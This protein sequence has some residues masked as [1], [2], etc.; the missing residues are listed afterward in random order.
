VKNFWLLAVL[1]MGMAAPAQAQAGEGE[2]GL[3]LGAV[4]LYR[5][6]GATRVKALLEVPHSLLGTSADGKLRFWIGIRVQDSTGL[7]IMDRGWAQAA[8]AVAG[9]RSAASIEMLEFAVAPGRYTLSVRVHDSLSGKEYQASR[10]I[11]GFATAPMTSDL[12]LTP[13]L[14]VADPADTVPRGGE[15]R[16]GNLVLVATPYVRVAP[17]AGQLYYMLEAYAPRTDT[18]TISV[19]VLT[20]QGVSLTRTKPRVLQVDSGGSIVSGGL[21]LGGVPQGKYRL[22]VYASIG[23]RDTTGEAEF[24]VRQPEIAQG[25]GVV[26]TDE[27]YFTNLTGKQLDSLAGALVYIAEP[28]EMAV[29]KGN[30]SPQAKVRFLT[31]FWAKRDP[32]PGQPGN[33]ARD[34]FYARIGYVDREF[35]DPGRGATPGWRTDRG[36][37][38]LK[39]GP[40]DDKWERPQEGR[41]PPLEVWRYTKTRNKYFIFADRSRIGLFSLA[42][43]D[44]V[45]EPGRP[46]WQELIG[47]YG[48]QAVERYLGVDLGLRGGQP[49]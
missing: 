14:R 24:S 28:G 2:E 30:L 8:R 48:L 32:T 49:R 16:H 12:V 41:T 46:D 37:I 6:E 25:V 13:A 15:W 39:Y 5:G 20:D 33:G 18:A 42:H 31:A 3:R 40:P 10:Q 35:R 19:E 1:G 34:E 43:S 38:Y 47:W 26:P 36:R 27:D 29:Y 21:S 22:R 44:E 9:V 45:K 7:T 17:A 23:G 11:V 4:R